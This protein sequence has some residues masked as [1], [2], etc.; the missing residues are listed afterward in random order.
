MARKLA[1]FSLTLVLGVMTGLLLAGISAEPGKAKGA[2]LRTALEGI[3]GFELIVWRSSFAPDTATGH[4]RHPGYEVVYVLGGAI[5]AEVDGR[6]RT[7]ESG[8]VLHVPLGATMAVKNPKGGET[9][10]TL[11]FLLARTGEPLSKKVEAPN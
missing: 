6:T 1:A 4:H 11:V 3:D 8:E 5:E 7:V 2:L 10:E 9:S